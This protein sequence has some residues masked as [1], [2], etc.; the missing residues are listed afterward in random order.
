MYT[1]AELLAKLHFLP[2]NT[3]TTPPL[4]HHFRHLMVLVVDP[5]PDVPISFL[6][7]CAT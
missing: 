5:P 4:L 2:S 7:F 1:S 6:S 3:T